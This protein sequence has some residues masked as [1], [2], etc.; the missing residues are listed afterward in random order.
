MLLFYSFALPLAC[1]VEAATKGLAH[2]LVTNAGV[3]QD[4]AQLTQAAKGVATNVT[5]LG[6]RLERGLEVR[7]SIAERCSLSCR[8]S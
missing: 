2:E 8:T 4:V 6:T 7:S 5:R 3:G 1:Q